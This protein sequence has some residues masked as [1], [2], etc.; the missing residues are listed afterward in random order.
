V[1]EVTEWVLHTHESDHAE[2]GGVCI[3]ANPIMLSAEGFL[4]SNP[5]IGPKKSKSNPL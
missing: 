3:S 5:N 4:S 1:Q 2:Y